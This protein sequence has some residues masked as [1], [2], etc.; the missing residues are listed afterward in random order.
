[1]PGP[2]TAAEAKAWIQ[3]A[4]PAGRYTPSAHLFV[5][6]YQRKLTMDDVF[7]AVERM[8]K[9]EPYTNGAPCHGGTCWRVF[10]P[11]VDDDATIAIGVEAYTD[12][13]RRRVLVV[14]FF[15]DT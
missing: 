2:T 8:T 12:K 9:I 14:T 11:N 13:N 7:V 1:M 4:I 6:Q 10:G 15:E 3:E 5:R